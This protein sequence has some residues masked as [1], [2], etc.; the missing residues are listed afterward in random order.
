MTHHPSIVDNPFLLI[1]TSNPYAPLK[2]SP[3]VR[4]PE[5]KEE[6]QEEDFR[7]PRPDD[8][9]IY[10]SLASAPAGKEDLIGSLKE[11]IEERAGRVFDQNDGDAWQ[12][13]LARRGNESHRFLHQHL[14]RPDPASGMDAAETR[15]YLES[16]AAFVDGAIGQVSDPS[17]KSSVL[18]SYVETTLLPMYYGDAYPL[19]HKLGQGLITNGGARE[20]PLRSLEAKQ[21]ELRALSELSDLA[22]SPMSLQEYLTNKTPATPGQPLDIDAMLENLA[23]SITAACEASS[24]TQDFLQTIQSSISHIAINLPRKIKEAGVF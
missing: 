8:W 5:A 20:E 15:A 4:R 10:P 14:C 17:E 11:E 1:P 22:H 12:R 2:L 24:P 19:L 9:G 6:S 21:S 13:T 16:V 3:S 23:N 18:A 7:A